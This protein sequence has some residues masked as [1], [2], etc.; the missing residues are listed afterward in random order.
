MFIQH[1]MLE[2][3]LFL[4]EKSKISDAV[5]FLRN[6]SDSDC[7][8]KTVLAERCLNFPVEKIAFLYPVKHKH[9]ESVISLL[10]CYFVRQ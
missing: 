3:M 5:L 9:S 6:N 1:Q 8:L 2:S 7:T 10:A 4:N